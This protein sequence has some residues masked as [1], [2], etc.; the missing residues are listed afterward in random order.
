MYPDAVFMAYP[1]CRPRVL[2]L[3]DY[4][5]STG[6]MFEVVEKECLM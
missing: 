1:E 6:Q 3:A 2:E 5:V 4:V